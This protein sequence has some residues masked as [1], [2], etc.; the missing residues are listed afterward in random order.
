MAEAAV[1]SGARAFRA[2]ILHMKHTRAWLFAA[3][4][5]VLCV[6]WGVARAQQSTAAA[7]P[8]GAAAL[9]Q[10]A[11]GDSIVLP[12][13]LIAGEQATLAVLDASGALVASAPVQVAGREFLTDSTGRVLFAAP[14][15]PG[16]LTARL[17]GSE[18]QFSAN[19]IGGA[20][21]QS[22][23]AGGAVSPPLHV[24]SV[25][26]RD[27]RFE[28]DGAGFRGDADRDRVVLGGQ[29]ALVLAA[30]PVSLVVL[31]NPATPAGPAQL[32]IDAAGQSF[33]ASSI[34][35][36][37]L[38]VSGP[39][40][41]L[42]AG[43]HTALVLRATGTNAPLVVEVRNAAPGVI[44]L[45][46]GDVQRLTTSGGADNIATIE[47]TALKAG[48]YSL[49]AR[50]IPGAA[51]PDIAAAR[52]ALLEA[53]KSANGKWRQRIDAALKGLE[54]NPRDVARYRDEIASWSA[55]HPPAKLAQL[56]TE[57]QTALALH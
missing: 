11:P 22:A 44:H 43:R 29:L 13:T 18:D 57:A 52:K 7:V 9:P 53:R 28:I 2:T 1:P 45:A 46:E 10:A 5:A 34:V 27:D 8:A 42:A 47:F 51:L 56:F 24:P 55:E 37:T 17:R 12:P 50:V 33:A 48:D 36:V 40:E 31:P 20:R 39:S 16:V 32:K 3:A 49:V 15:N 35:V 19:V 38:D 26:A 21:A 41:A 54:T 25:I 6:A 30:S 4:V 23:T 14:E